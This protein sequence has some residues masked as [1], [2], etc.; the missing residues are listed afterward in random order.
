MMSWLPIA[1]DFR[2]DLRT[3]LDSTEPVYCLENLAAL[4]AYRLGFLETVQLDRAYGRSD[5]KQAPGLL[6]MRFAVLASST[7]DAFCHWMYA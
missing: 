2:G 5:L 1:P 6:P 4:A 3:A 7:V